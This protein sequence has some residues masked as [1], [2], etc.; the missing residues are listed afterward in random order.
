MSG[1]RSKWKVPR[2]RLTRDS[3]LFLSGLGG[4]VHETFFT[5]LDR[6]DLLVLF[7]AMVGLPAFLRQD[8][9]RRFRNTLPGHERPLD[10]EEGM[11]YPGQNS[12]QVSGQ[13]SGSGWG[14]NRRRPKGDDDYD[15][16]DAG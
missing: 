3:V 14:P 13:A 2:L 16:L 6:P 8:E 10:V 11:G 7:M 15:D 9:Y 12:G 5:S 4:I 1:R